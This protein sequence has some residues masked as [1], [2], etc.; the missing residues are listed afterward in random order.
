MLLGSICSL[1][2]I[3]PPQA[4]EEILE[5]N[6]ASE[7]SR[8]HVISWQ[9]LLLIFLFV[10]EGSGCHILQPPPM[11]E[12][13]IDQSTFQS[14]VDNHDRCLK[15]H[16]L[17]KI[18]EII[19][20][21]EQAPIPI[22]A[23]ESPIPLPDF[24]IKIVAKPVSRLAVDPKSLAASCTLHAGRVALQQG[25]VESAQQHFHTLVEKYQDPAYSFYVKQANNSLT[26]IDNLK[27]TTIQN[28]EPKERTFSPQ[29][30]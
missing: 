10:V 20:H 18:N 14:Y 19:D 23:Y 11:G 24:I 5:M 21:L 28:L 1:T 26:E 8:L 7:Q 22:S 30:S 9:T 27:K 16:N 12:A 25:N 2:G 3:H 4:G 13:A 6:P 15:S 17:Q 29:K